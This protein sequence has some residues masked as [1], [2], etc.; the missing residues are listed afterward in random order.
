MLMTIII[1]VAAA[2]P[3]ARPREKL[4]NYSKSVIWI[5]M[6]CIHLRV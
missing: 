6:V 2:Q 5:I 3:C 1:V 4:Y